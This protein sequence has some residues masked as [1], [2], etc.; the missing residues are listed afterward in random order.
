MSSNR[1][2]K[3]AIR[4]VE[5]LASIHRTRLSDRMAE[6]PSVPHELRGSP[7]RALTE[8]F[9]SL[10]ENLLQEPH[11]ARSAFV[12]I[13]ERYLDGGIRR[14][15]DALD[16]DSRTSHAL[17]IWADRKNRIRAG[18]PDR[19]DGFRSLVQLEGVTILRHPDA[20][21]IYRTEVLTRA[22]GKPD[23]ADG[24]EILRNDDDTLIIR[25]TTPAA[26]CYWASGTNW[27]TR[28]REVA[29]RYLAADA[30]YVIVDKDSG[31]KYQIHFP[32]GQ[33]TDRH[34]EPMTATTFAQLFP[35]A[36][37]FASQERRASLAAVT[38]EYV[39]DLAGP[40]HVA[41]A[42]SGNRRAVLACVRALTGHCG[43]DEMFL[44][45]VRDVRRPERLLLAVTDDAFSAPLSA[46]VTVLCRFVRLT[47]G[48]QARRALTALR[49]LLRDHPHLDGDVTRIVASTCAAAFE[50]ADDD[51]VADVS[52]VLR[53]T[54]GRT[55]FPFVFVVSLGGSSVP[56][57]LL[58]D[59][60]ARPKFRTVVAR[61]L[62]DPQPAY[63]SLL[64]RLF[65]LWY[66]PH[67][68]LPLSPGLLHAFPPDDWAKLLT[69]AGD[70][71]RS[72]PYLGELAHL[73]VAT[74]VGNLPQPDKEAART[75]LSC[76]PAS[77]RAFMVEAAKRRTPALPIM[78]P[79][80]G[81]LAP[82]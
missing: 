48:E 4:C 64:E 1:L 7:L 61:I 72:V 32:T 6:D 34:D 55:D 35:D 60:F 12:W 52:R 26:A 45:M 42:L 20:P 50:K 28:S 77:V 66:L 11:R 13:V 27:C 67:T 19:L 39:P 40:E 53:M 47:Q 25:V 49:V 70:G 57:H 51:L 2:P 24:T 74:A 38:L 65:R 63:M 82:P 21:P 9:L 36:Y 8:L 23:I 17:G 16:D 81:L 18:L 44:R 58:T 73:F 75:V 62:R 14:F 31:E 80:D 5:H 41:A 3:W 69:A 76:V 22:L 46:I 79:V 33:Y 15:E 43:T 68:G 56:D 10:P 37:L 78:D 54:A 71:F 29:E 59:L 30:L